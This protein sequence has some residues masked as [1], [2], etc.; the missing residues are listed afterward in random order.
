MISRLAALLFVGL[1]LGAGAAQARYLTMSKFEIGVWNDLKGPAAA[2][3]FHYA[4]S[5]IL[6]CYL[7]SGEEAK[8]PLTNL[9]NRVDAFYSDGTRNGDDVLA[10]IDFNPD[11]GS[12]LVY[13]AVLFH[14]GP[15]GYQF[16]HDVEGLLGDPFAA[17]FVDGKVIVSS[18][19]LLPDDAY[20]CATGRTEW[21]V[22][23]RT[24]AAVY[25]AGYLDPSWRRGDQS[26][27][28]SGAAPSAG[29]NSLPSRR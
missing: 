3:I 11:S 10:I 6:D 8:C 7:L 21:T 4:Q 12:I 22:D 15:N 9:V 27:G 24:G 20:C 1:Q 13:D 2:A 17:R 25:R 28:L 23:M 26:G 16:A 18:H 14:R 19:T 5:R 29:L